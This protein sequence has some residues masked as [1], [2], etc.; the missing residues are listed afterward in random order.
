PLKE[1]ST[2]NE[3]N[4]NEKQDV[5]K[6][7]SVDNFD[8]SSD[9]E[10]NYADSSDPLELE[11]E[12]VTIKDELSDCEEAPEKKEKIKRKPKDPEYEEMIAK[13]LEKTKFGN[14]TALYLRNS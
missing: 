14:E 2:Q 11:K 8:S 10:N 5:K 9:N 13:F 4:Q 6:E 12:D 1:E 3:E 7:F